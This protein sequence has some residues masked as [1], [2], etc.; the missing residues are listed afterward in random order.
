MKT[1]NSRWDHNLVL[2]IKILLID[3][4]EDEE[5]LLEDELFQ[6][7]IKADI[8]RVDSAPSM[9]QALSE[10]QFDI[11]LLDYVMPNF[12]A[13]KALEIY[14]KLS[15]DLP[16]IVMSGQVGE[17]IA[18]EMMRAGAHDYI[19]KH[20]RA[21]LIP[22]IK[23]E[24]QDYQQ[25]IEQRR[26]EKQLSELK[27][28]NQLILETTGNG[29]FGLDLQGRHTFVNLAATKL[30]GYEVEELIGAKSHATW[31]YQYPDGRNYPD[32]QCPI[33]KTL[34]QNKIQQGEEY[35]IRKDGT[36]FPVLYNSNPII[37]DGQIIGSVVSFSDISDQKQ[38]QENLLKT[39][40]SLTT[41]S[42]CDQILVRADNEE[43][44]L[45]DICRVL[46]TSGQ[47]NLVWISFREN[48]NLYPLA[49]QPKNDDTVNFL[50]HRQDQYGSDKQSSN[51]EFKALHSGDTII[52]CKEDIIKEL[53]CSE[54][55][56][57]WIALPLIND[58]KVFAVLNVLSESLDDHFSTTVDLLEELAGDIAF[59]LNVIHTRTERDRFQ[60]ELL[61]KE[62]L[63]IAQSRHAAMGEMISMIAH[64]WR[65]PISIIAMEANNM[66]A[67]IEF[68]EVELKNF[69][70][71]AKLIIEQTLHLSKTIDDFRNFFRPG[72]KKEQIIPKEV[73]EEC[74]AIVGKSLENENIE[75]IKNYQSERSLLLHSR[76]LLQVIINIIKNA[77]EALTEHQSKNRKILIDIFED[78]KQDNSFLHIN[79]TDN[80]G[81]IPA[82]IKDKIFEPYY[83]TKDKKSGTG[84]GLY[85][86]KTIIE[87]HLNGEIEINN[88]ENGAQ[89]SLQLPMR[90]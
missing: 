1:P 22:A 44:L 83:S 14:H 3:D 62:E 25:R 57:K 71:D 90:R 47:Y 7:N 53:L 49:W 63:M 31:H 19:S 72:K 40:R 15:L 76:E 54:I 12:S 16:L 32:K 33:F 67:D 27:N 55:I 48:N 70:R 65:Q 13:P 23:R 34:T 77:K 6:K 5:F 79:I 26:T 28:R 50:K 82:E 59:G 9:I 41:L 43:K 87:K 73:M 68:D 52:E 29:I 38:T 60:H 8:L 17:D 89:F 69:S 66:L 36:F 74:L 4:S 39:N 37:K 42:D 30:L 20:N 58:G 64:Q 56:K 11:L 84:L 51:P 86:S 81:G 61:E 80:A 45:T 21:R 18:I 75:V 88:T 2:E 85:M 24:L 10:Q 46:H 35:F 78:N